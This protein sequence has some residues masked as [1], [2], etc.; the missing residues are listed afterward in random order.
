MSIEVAPGGKYVTSKVSP[1]KI[2][3]GG[4]PNWLSIA[5]QKPYTNCMLTSAFARPSDGS[6]IKGRYYEI[7]HIFCATSL[8][9]RQ[10]WQKQYAIVALHSATLYHF[11]L[12]SHCCDMCV[13]F[14]SIAD[15]IHPAVAQ[16]VPIAFPIVVFR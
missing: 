16:C 14:V 4:R 8:P 15:H 5:T 12:R 6:T 7:L 10:R 2:V 3:T 1:A 9:C 13:I 11:T